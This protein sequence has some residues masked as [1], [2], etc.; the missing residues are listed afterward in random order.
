MYKLVRLSFWLSF[1][2]P[3]PL[4]FLLFQRLMFFA[5]G[6]LLIFTFTQLT[7]C[8]FISSACSFFLCAEIPHVPF[9]GSFSNFKIIIS[10]FP[11][12]YFFAYS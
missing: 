3:I 10:I 4:S 9:I 11:S 6:C 2:F 5:I 7:F 1:Y 12:L 8:I